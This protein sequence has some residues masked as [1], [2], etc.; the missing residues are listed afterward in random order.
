MAVVTQDGW[1][2]L[3]LLEQPCV[4]I[5]ARL[6]RLITAPLAFPVGVG[7]ASDAGRR[8]VRAVLRTETLVAG[9]RLNQRACRREVI[10]RQQALL[11][12]QAHDFR[13]E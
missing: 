6:M 8:I 1:R 2:A 3:A 10:P 12:R 13:K 9:P 11:I 5:R 7:V 4:R